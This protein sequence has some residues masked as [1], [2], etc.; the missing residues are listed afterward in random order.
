V[1]RVLLCARGGALEIPAIAGALRARNAEPVVFDSAAF[2]TSAPLSLVYERAGF[3][4][5]WPRP[6]TGSHEPRTDSLE[7]P[8]GSLEPRTGSLEPRTGSLEPRTGSLEPRT[9]SHAPLAGSHAPLAGSFESRTGSLESRTSSLEPRTGSLEP[10]TGSLEP[11]TGSVEPLA[12]SR[13]RNATDGITA[14][15]QSLAVGTALPAM[16]PGM[17]ETC[18]AASELALVGL[19]DSLQVFQLDP[20]WAKA[21]A[22]NKP[23]QLRVAQRVGLDI[24]A[25]IITNDPD[26]VRAFA[27]D[28]GPLIMKMLVQP[29]STGPSTDETEV[30]FTTAMSPA[31]LDALDGLDLCPMIFQEQV[32]NHLDVRAT[33]IGR[34]IFAAAIDATARGGDDL[35]WRRQGYALDHAPTWAPYQLPAEIEASL[36]ALA[37]H[38]HLNYG[39][40]DFIIRA[41]GRPIFLELNAS[42]S[43][44]FLGPALTHAIASAIADVLTDPGARRIANH[45]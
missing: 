14:V 15:W 42:G 18:V 13:L 16:D 21:R 17:R 27:R 20:H 29:S 11:H 1:S 28:R 12:G 19:L 2:P 30:V 22:D 39:A 5:S 25:T 26:A 8:T 7:P 44:G 24:P 41:D 40:A 43:F 10:R 36:F 23:H 38:F 32:P 3:H 31:D 35:D 6:P 4:G 34:R 33:I 9:G 45:D 37:D